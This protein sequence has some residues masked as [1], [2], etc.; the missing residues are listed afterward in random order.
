MKNYYRVMLGKKSVYAAAGFDAGVIGATFE[1]NQDLSADFPD[2]WRAFNHKFIPIFLAGHPDKTKIGA[3]LA[4]GALWTVCKGLFKGDIVLSPD[5][6]GRHLAGEVTGD[7]VYAPNQPLP[8][9][10][11]VK[12]L[13]QTIDRADMSEALKNS[14]GS[15]GTVSAITQYAAE[16]EKLLS[17]GP[18]QTLVPTDATV[19]DPIAFALEKHL[20]HFLVHN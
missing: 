8:H 14:A 17:G 15:I 13:S 11:S 2:D 19:E 3:G 16:L 6:T 10:R 20:E 12:W 5:G 4:C 18:A 7:Y 9:R 1:I